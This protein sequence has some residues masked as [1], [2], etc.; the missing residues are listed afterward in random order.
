M[1]HMQF[2]FLTYVLHDPPTPS[3]WFLY[4]KNIYIKFKTR[5][6]HCTTSF[7]TP[8]TASLLRHHILF[9][10]LSLSSASVLPFTHQVTYLSFMTS[11]TF[12]RK[13]TE[14][15]LPLRQRIREKR[16][17]TLSRL[18]VW[19]NDTKCGV[20]CKPALGRDKNMQLHELTNFH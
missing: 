18:S 19:F 14:W 4:P 11:E 15:K 8:A 17:P 5:S 9:G 6:R 3:H 10:I 1:S 7:H 13:K 2:Q 16:G 20:Q 12:C